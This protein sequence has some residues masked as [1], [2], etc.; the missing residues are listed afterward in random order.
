MAK[1][2]SCSTST[3]IYSSFF[4]LIRWPLRFTYMVC[5]LRFT[6]LK[7]NLLYNGHRIL[8]L[9]MTN[10]TSGAIIFKRTW[11]VLTTNM[12]Y[13]TESIRVGTRAES[14]PRSYER[15]ATA[16]AT[17][18][19]SSDHSTVIYFLFFIKSS[20]QLA[21]LFI[22]TCKIRRLLVSFCQDEKTV[23]KLLTGCL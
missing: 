4:G 20:V 12:D 18:P 3:S 6:V 13:Y 8:V 17:L 19:S 2:F 9:P 1:F 23:T 22:F 11:H 16:L 10:W 15:G 14:N 21:I 7:N 5:M